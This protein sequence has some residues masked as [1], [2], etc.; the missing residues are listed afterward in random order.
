MQT[1]N[2]LMYYQFHLQ[3]RTTACSTVQSI[4]RTQRYAADIY[5]RQPAWIAALWPACSA[6]KA[7]SNCHHIT[8][9]MHNVPESAFV[10]AILLMLC[11][12]AGN[13]IQ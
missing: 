9:R 5:A 13:S 1:S 7:G 10:Q 8:I 3:F 6:S 12:K 2:G 11:L 4:A